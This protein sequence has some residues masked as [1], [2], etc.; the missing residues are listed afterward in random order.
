MPTIEAQTKILAEL[1]VTRPELALFVVAQYGIFVSPEDLPS[2]AESECY[3][4]LIPPE[5]LPSEE[6]CRAALTDCLAKGWLRVIDESALA[7]IRGDLRAGGFL[8]PVYRLPPIGSVDFTRTGVELWLRYCDLSWPKKRS[9]SAYIDVVHEKTARYFPSRAAAVAEVEIAGKEDD[10]VSI[11][12]PSPTGPWRAQWWRR[13]PEGYRIDIEQR[14]QWQGRSCGGSEECHL[15]RPPEKEDWQRLRHVLDRHNVTFPEWILLAEM[16]VGPRRF[17]RTKPPLSPLGDPGEPHGEALSADDYHTALDACL[18]Y[19]WLR[20][21]DQQVV[22]EVHEL[23]RN[24]PATLAL[25]KT[26]RYHPDECRLGSDPS[27]PGKLVPLPASPEQRYGE[28]DFSPA[29]AA[30]YRMISA[31]WLG[32]DWEDDLIISKR[33]YW[34]AHYYCE[35]EEGFELI[36]PEHVARGEVIPGRS[37][38]PDRPLVCPLVEA[39][40]SGLPHGTQNR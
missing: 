26:A 7:A 31:E 19:G 6:A 33:Y 5:D 12:G 32:P 16:E 24:D 9:P 21:I 17:E 25:P 40:S 38:Y 14:R 23:L 8:G 18:R 28:I 39:I 4:I 36:I 2:F 3:G 30:L 35:A 27:R 22:G 10:V 15:P 37:S 20:V 11:T 29:G 13:F 1:G 34:E